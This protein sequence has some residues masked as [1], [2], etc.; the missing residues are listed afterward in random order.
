VKVGDIVRFKKK[1][2]GLEKQRGIIVG[3]DGFSV[4]VYWYKDAK[5]MISELKEFL[6]VVS[7]SR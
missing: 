6:E 1:V 5:H 4:D 3:D 7:E 2:L